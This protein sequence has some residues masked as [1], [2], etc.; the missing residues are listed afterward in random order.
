MLSIYLSICF[1][2][3]F[4]SPFFILFPHFF[5]FFYIFC[6]CLFLYCSLFFL[7]FSSYSF[8]TL[9]RSL[10]N[11][12]YLSLSLSLHSSPLFQLYTLSIVT[13][14]IFFFIQPLSFTFHFLLLFLPCLPHFFHPLSFHSLLFLLMP[15]FSFSHPLLFLIS[16]YRQFQLKPP[17]LSLS[18]S[19]S[20]YISLSFF[21]SLSFSLSLSL[22]FFIS[23]SLSLF[24]CLSLSLPP[25]L[26]HSFFISLSLYLSCS[27]LFFRLYLMHFRIQFPT[28]SLFLRQNLFK[29]FNRRAAASAAVIN[30]KQTTKACHPGTYNGP[31]NRRKS[32]E[33]AEI[34]FTV[35]NPPSK[36]PLSLSTMINDYS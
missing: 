21:I 28:I 8:Y 12:S 2:S 35:P 9:L 22:S 10:S 11:F 5:F 36:T 1:L 34:H 19:L 3:I 13:V 17:S 27:V 32:T 7:T 15:S 24:L 14:F 30:T 20:L 31:F 4:I 25:S 26:S 18:L 23:L 29:A 6:F 16:F 33:V